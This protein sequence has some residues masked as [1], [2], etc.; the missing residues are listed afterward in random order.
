[1]ASA[2]R[3][4]SRCTSAV[5]SRA[6]AAKLFMLVEHRP[7]LPPLAQPGAEADEE[8]VCVGGGAYLTVRSHHGI[9]GVVGR[10]LCV[11]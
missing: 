9:A 4:A 2:R 6:R 5:Y 11:R 1:M 10:W 3:G 7:I 8:C